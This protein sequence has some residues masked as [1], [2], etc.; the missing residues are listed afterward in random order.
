MQA[1]HTLALHKPALSQL[2]FRQA[3]LADAET[4]AYN[5]AYGGTIAFPPERWAGWYSRWVADASGEKFYRYLLDTER[6]QF[7]GEAAYRYDAERNLYICDI[8]VLAAERGNGYGRQG[9]LLLCDAA[10]E[11][12]VPAL[13][14]DIAIDNPSV[15]LFL[16]CGFTEVYRAETYIMVTKVLG[17]AATV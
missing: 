9:L 11:A 8:L 2:T 5:H 17:E 1:P 12:G 3:L 6:S 15:G 14:D 7:V 4:M 13:Y 10:K 16:S